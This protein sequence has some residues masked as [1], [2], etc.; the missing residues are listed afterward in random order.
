MFPAIAI[1]ES[2][3]PTPAIS[4]AQAESILLTKLKHDRAFPSIKPECLYLVLDEQT[5]AYYQFSVRFDQSKCGGNSASDLLERFAVMKSNGKVKYY[6]VAIAH[7]RPYQWFIQHR[8][9]H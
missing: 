5:P 3:T 1:I 6:D 7:V 2:A 9:G 8:Q 4:Q